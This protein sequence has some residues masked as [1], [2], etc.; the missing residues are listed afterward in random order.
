MKKKFIIISFSFTLLLILS[1]DF[2]IAKNKNIM[3][4]IILKSDTRSISMDKYI[5]G[6]LDKLMFNINQA[7]KNSDEKL[8]LYL[9]ELVHNNHYF[10]S[11]TGSIP[12]PLFNQTVNILKKNKKYRKIFISNKKENIVQYIKELCDLKWNNSHHLLGK[13]YIIEIYLRLVGQDISPEIKDELINFYRYFRNNKAEKSLLYHYR[14]YAIIY[15]YGSWLDDSFEES[16]N[17]FS[18][19]SNYSLDNPLS[20]LLSLEQIMGVKL[21]NLIA[22]WTYNTLLN[23]SDIMGYK[24]KKYMQQMLKLIET[25]YPEIFVYKIENQEKNIKLSNN[26][27]NVILPINYSSSRDEALII[28]FCLYSSYKVANFFNQDLQ[29]MNIYINET[30]YVP[31]SHINSKTIYTK[32]STNKKWNSSAITHEL[33]HIYT[34][35]FIENNPNNIFLVHGI[36]YFIEYYLRD[37]LDSYIEMLKNDFINNYVDLEDMFEMSIQ[38]QMNYG[39]NKLDQQFVFILYFLN[40]KYGINKVKKYIDSDLTIKSL[41]SIFDIKISDLNV[42]LKEYYNIARSSS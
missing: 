5:D 8:N 42:N 40:E 10:D 34:N 14:P 32:L 16:I 35:N 30:L 33:L 22:Q 37:N 7:Q 26:N 31:K 39:L 17:T 15:Y 25:K 28:S 13:A 38:D 19:I 11:T 1:L 20:Y 36:I 3:S 41:E 2:A 29:N 27:L 4:E 6:K 18:T 12:F 24:N 21:K 9:D 23:Y